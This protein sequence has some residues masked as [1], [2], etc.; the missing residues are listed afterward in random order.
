MPPS[1]PDRSKIRKRVKNSQSEAKTSKATGWKT[2]AAAGTAAVLVAAGGFVAYSAMHKNV[3]LDVDGTVVEVSTFSADIQSVLDEHHI[4]V[5]ERDLVAPIAASDVPD[6]GE[7]VVRHA[8]L[9]SAEVDGQTASVWST[10][11]TADEAITDLQARSDGAQLVASRGMSSGRTALGLRLGLGQNV[12]V[13]ADGATQT[14]AAK[15]ASVDGVLGQVS[16]AVADRDRVEMT[17]DPATGLTITVK[18]VTTA[19]RT[20][21]AEVPFESV[22]QDDPT[23]YVGTNTVSQAGVPGVQTTTYGVVQVDGQEVR[24][25]MES[26]DVTTAPVQQITLVGSKA[27]PVVVKPVAPKTTTPATTDTTTD[28]TTATVPSGGGGLNWAAL[29]ACES[30]GRPTAVS[31]NGKYHGLYQFSVATWASVGGSGLPSQ[32]SAE[33]QTMRAQT[34]YNRSGA[35][36]WPHCGPRLFS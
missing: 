34:L 15:A 20:E 4:Q 7:I 29:A 17:S 14:V 36:Q 28:T 11:L 6:G 8:R 30:G 13:V 27:K 10:A 19:E 3:T 23:R 22:E 16:V 26:Q 1:C 32:A 31:A 9:I 33:E 12:T 18:R 21:T 25:V 2:W 24:R 35:G 5:G